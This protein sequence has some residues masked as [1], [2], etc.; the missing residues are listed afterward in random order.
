MLGNIQNIYLKNLK[1]TW[2]TPFRGK[3]CKH[4]VVFFQF[5]LYTI[6]TIS[7]H[8]GVLYITPT[9]CP[10]FNHLHCIAQWLRIWTPGPHRLPTRASSATY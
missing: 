10:E 3:C 1:A 6:H 8:W 9:F 4:L 7:Q 5:A 2:K